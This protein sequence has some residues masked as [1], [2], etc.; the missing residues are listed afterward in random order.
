LSFTK[1][2]VEWALLDSYVD[3][4]FYQQKTYVNL[5]SANVLCIVP[6]ISFL[7]ISSNQYPELRGNEAVIGEKERLSLHDDDRP[8][9][10]ESND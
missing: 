1:F 8:S 7:M 5:Y 2:A 4:D 10:L 9:R 6:W 3:Q